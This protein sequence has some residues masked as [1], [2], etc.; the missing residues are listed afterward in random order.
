MKL[1]QSGFKKTIDDPQYLNLTMVTKNDTGWYTCLVANS[2]GMNYRS[3]Y[4][5][6]LTGKYSQRS[7]YFYAPGLKNIG[8]LAFGSSVRIF[9]L[10]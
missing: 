8:H 3:A 10:I 2:I 9:R 5:S 7:C 1:Q 4:L 6:V